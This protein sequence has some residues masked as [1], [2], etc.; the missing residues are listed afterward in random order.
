MDK[1]REDFPRLYFLSNDEVLDVL[2]TSNDPQKLMPVVRK[3]FPGI[4]SIKFGFPGKGSKPNTP[5]DAALK[6]VYF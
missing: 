3:C 2:V 5:F 6:G 1:I 4:Q